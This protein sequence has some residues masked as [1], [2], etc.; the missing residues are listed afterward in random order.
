L[1]G[2]EVAPQ[3][4]GGQPGVDDVLDEDDAAAGQVDVEVLDDAHDPGRAG[5]GAVGRH[6]HEVDL[7]RQADGPHEVGEEDEGALE[8][9]DEQR[10]LVRV[11]EGDLVAELGDAGPDLLLADDDVPQGRVLEV[12]HRV[13]GGCLGHGGSGGGADVAGI[14]R[15][16]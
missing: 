6:G 16:A 1:A 13:L 14:V 8:D 10:R 2:E 4:G 12:V 3:G 11:V 5:R 15:H 7:D 9:A